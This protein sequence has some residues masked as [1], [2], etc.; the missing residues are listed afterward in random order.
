MGKWKGKAAIQLKYIPENR[1]MSNGH[2]NLW[3]ICVTYT[4][5]YIA[6]QILTL[7]VGLNMLWVDKV[8]LIALC[9]LMAVT[10]KFIYK[11]E[12]ALLTWQ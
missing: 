1:D 3:S 12:S 11:E 6:T 10:W 9:T 5:L 4:T 8:K 2:T 7:I